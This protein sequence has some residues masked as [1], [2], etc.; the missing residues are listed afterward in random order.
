[1]LI[2]IV[3]LIIVGVV[4]IIGLAFKKIRIPNIGWIFNRAAVKGRMGEISVSHL[5]NQLSPEYHVFNDVYILHVNSS[6][7]IDHVVVSQ[8]GVFCIETK[9]YSGLI[10]GSENSDMW[11]QNMY[12]RKYRFNNPLIQN[13]SHVKALS[14]FL[15]LSEN[16]FVSVVVFMNRARLMIQTS[17]NVIY[18][19]QLLYFI[20]SFSKTVCSTD[21][22]M[23]CI[24]KLANT[25]VVDEQVRQSHIFNVQQKIAQK[26][27][28]LANGIC[29]RCG[30]KLV[31]RQGK[32]GF[33]YGCS[34]Y[35]KCQFTHNI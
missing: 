18:A 1:M 25:K 10:Y 24:N 21:I 33:F 4:S 20:S 35:P 6:I 19:S 34:N 13:N 5:L 15:N 2:L 23:D 9:N 11:T 17:G 32:Y 8:Y 16:Y 7:Q 30:G 28:K 29:P 31:G 3:V 12:G 14:R 22:I 27:F 26:N